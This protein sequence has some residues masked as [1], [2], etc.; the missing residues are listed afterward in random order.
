MLMNRIRILLI[1]LLTLC[2]TVPVE[3]QMLSADARRM[4]AQ[5]L[6]NVADEAP[7]VRISLMYTR[8]DNFT[9]RVLYTSLREAYLHPIT[10]KA[11]KKAD[12]RLRQLRPDLRLMVMDATRPMS[13]QQTMWD[14]VKNTNQKIY[15]SNPKNGGGL[16]NYGLAVDLTLCDLNGDTLTMGV[17]IDNMTSLSHIDKEDLL[18]KQG[19]ISR[20]AYDNRRLLR[21]VM[22]YAGF[23]PL[24]TEWWHFNIRTRAQAKQ[25]FKVV[26]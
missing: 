22:R 10:M 16:H 2:A 26:E 9:G 20:E 6:K 15:V 13:V 11:L 25:Y 12:E 8:A 23:K 3:A 19:K 21:E 18:L 17:K 7:E 5:G 4:A 14:A 24:R 1:L